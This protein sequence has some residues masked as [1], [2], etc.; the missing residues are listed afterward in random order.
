M[1]QMRAIRIMLRVDPR[2]SCREGFEKLDTVPCLCIY[3]LMLLVVKNPI[4][5]QSNSSI[6]NLNTRQQDKLHVPS[7]RFPSIQTVVY[8]S[9]VKIFNQLP[10]SI[11]KFHGSVHIF[12]TK[13]RNFL[14]SNAFYSIEEFISTN[15][16]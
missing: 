15:H 10:Q 12:K 16:V 2:S 14:V 11:S 1:V 6:H 9:S 5:Y 3:A 4:I 8:Y 7:V 13:L